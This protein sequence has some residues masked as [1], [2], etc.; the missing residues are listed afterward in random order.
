MKN[1]GKEVF[2]IRREERERE[3]VAGA[4]GSCRSWRRK[5]DSE[6]F[7]RYTTNGTVGHSGGNEH[8]L[9]GTDRDSVQMC[10]VFL[11][12]CC[13]VVLGFVSYD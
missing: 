12:K 2:F 3:G 5:G 7:L 8:Q 11:R 9:F 13:C 4:G 6:P 1:K 10:K